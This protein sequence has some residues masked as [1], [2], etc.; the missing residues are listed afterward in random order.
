MLLFKD[1]INELKLLQPQVPA[2]Q[3]DELYDC[4]GNVNVIK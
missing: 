2:R 3:A 4:V 1:V